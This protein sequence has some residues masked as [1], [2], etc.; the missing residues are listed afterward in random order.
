VNLSNPLWLVRVDENRGSAVP[1]QC[2]RPAVYTPDYNTQTHFSLYHYQDDG[3]G[4]QLAIPLASYTGQTGDG[5]RDGGS[6][7]TDLRWVAPGGSP[8]W[9]Q[10]AIVPADCG[11]PTGGDYDPVACP[12]GSPAGPGRG[13]EIRLS[14]YLTDTMVDAEG[15]RFLYLDVASL[16]GSSENGF[17]IWAGPPGYTA[18][19]SSEANRRNLQVVDHHPE[20]FDA[21]ELQLFALG[22]QTQ[23]SNYSGTLDIPL[24]VLGQEYTSRTITVTL[25]DPDEGSR[26]PLTFYFD[27]M[28]PS[29]FSPE[30]GAGVDPAGRCFDE[31]PAYGEECDDQWVTPAF[32]MTIPAYAGNFYGG[33]LTARYQVGAGDTINWRLALPQTEP[34]ADNCTAYPIALRAD[35]FTVYPS[36][37]TVVT[38]TLPGDPINLYPTWGWG[39]PIPHPPYT[40]ANTDAYPWNY[41]GRP[42]NPWP[43]RPRSGYLYL[44]RERRSNREFCLAILGWRYFSKCAYCQPDLPWKQ[45]REFC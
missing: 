2:G 44:F 4:S 6:H 18:T 34:L 12:A 28:H 24:A 17:A 5:S 45:F 42:L 23:H 7:L 13:F 19:L 10:P 21:G 37:S 25:F 30:F 8:A 14:E 32:T 31:G 29:L 40:M 41:P 20:T 27:T 15:N 1:G 43:F 26:P 38:P 36:D 16:S 39:Y 11:S 3:S 22:Q 9:D 33:R 35:A